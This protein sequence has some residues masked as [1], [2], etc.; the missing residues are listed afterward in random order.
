[1]N[2]EAALLDIPSVAIDLSTNLSVLPNKISDRHNHILEAKQMGIFYFVSDIAEYDKLL[3]NLLS[4]CKKD[5][6][7]RSSKFDLN[8][9]VDTHQP[10]LNNLLELINS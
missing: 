8:Y 2:L 6:A 10:F 7:K 3:K 1:M 9:F 5:D 4:N